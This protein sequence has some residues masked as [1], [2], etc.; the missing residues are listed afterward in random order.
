MH[1]YLQYVIIP[2][3]AMQAIKPIQTRTTEKNKE[4]NNGAG[5]RQVSDVLNNEPNVSGEVPLSSPIP[6]K[7]PDSP[8]DISPSTELYYM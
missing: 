4:D 6:V 2:L 3:F 5:R 8:G 7:V 1:S